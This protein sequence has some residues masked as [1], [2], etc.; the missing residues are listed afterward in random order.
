MT[1]SCRVEDLFAFW[2]S[3]A[4]TRASVSVTDGISTHKNIPAAAGEENLIAFSSRHSFDA[5]SLNKA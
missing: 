2:S 3:R 1:S 4:G 5:G